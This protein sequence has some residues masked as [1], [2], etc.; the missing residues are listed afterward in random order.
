MVCA[1]IDHGTLL[2]AGL[3]PIVVHVALGSRSGVLAA[4]VVAV[5][6]RVAFGLGRHLLRGGGL[7]RQGLPVQYVSV[8]IL[9]VFELFEAC[10]RTLLE[11]EQPAEGI[12]ALGLQLPELRQVGGDGR[13]RARHGSLGLCVG[14]LRFLQGA[15]APLLHAP[16]GLVRSARV[17][18]GSLAALSVGGSFGKSCL[19]LGNARGDLGLES[20]EHHDVEGPPLAG[21]HGEHLGQAQEQRLVELEPLA[22]GHQR[23]GSLLGLVL[24]HGAVLQRLVHVPLASLQLLLLR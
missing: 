20:V 2:M 24:C 10:Q 23:R 12:V 3:V 18:H 16:G 21:P 17:A 8:H 5:V 7:R 15:D 14:G 13:P 22:D 19:E 6:A 9:C 11:G 4:D 1:A